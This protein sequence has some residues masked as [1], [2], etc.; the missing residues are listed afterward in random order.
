ML[1]QKAELVNSTFGQ[2]HLYLSF[3]YS[4][5]GPSV[6]IALKREAG[7]G[8][9]NQEIGLLLLVGESVKTCS[10]QN[11]VPLNLSRTKEFLGAITE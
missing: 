11:S 1:K 9:V 4:A 3:T 6:G 2:V 8:E 7:N 5:A 10:A